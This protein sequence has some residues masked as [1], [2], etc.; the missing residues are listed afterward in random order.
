MHFVSVDG[1]FFYRLIFLIYPA[2]DAERFPLQKQASKSWDKCYETW[3][4]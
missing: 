1:G 2:R 4:A 3:S